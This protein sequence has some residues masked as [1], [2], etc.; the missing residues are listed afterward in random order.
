[1]SG[2]T[3]LAAWPTS[4]LK[5]LS[6]TVPLSIGVLFAEAVRLVIFAGLLWGAGD[7]AVLWVK[8]HYD[9]RATR[10]L[11]ARLAYM[12][13]RWEKRKAHTR[14]RAPALARTVRVS[15]A[16]RLR[17]A[18]G[19]IRIALVIVCLETVLAGAV[20][21]RNTD[22]LLQQAAANPL[23]GK[24]LYVDPNSSAQRKAETLRRSR[25]QDAALLEQIADKPAARWLGGWANDIAREVDNAV[26]TITRT[27]AVA[28]FVAYNIPGRDC[29][30]Y[31]AGGANGGDADCKWIRSFASGSADVRRS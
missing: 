1:M 2:A 24:R 27:G 19:F 16:Q 28:V 9:I 6:S 26:S 11:V 15:G 23:A 31:S 13:R 3:D 20:L 14:R 21:P 18:L 22:A 7:L 4:E 8:S 5:V 25:P 29:G 17:R 30:Q 12:M 10:I